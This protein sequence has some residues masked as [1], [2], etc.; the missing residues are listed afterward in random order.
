MSRERLV[1]V[2]AGQAGV[3]AALQAR[4]LGYEGEITLLGDEQHLPYQRPH[5]SKAF[6]ES[7]DPAARPLVPESAY[8]ENDLQLI[9]GRRGTAIDREAGA[10]ELDDGTRLPYDRLVL[11]TGSRNRPLP[12]G[13]PSQDS[14][15][16]GLRTLA[17]AH[18]LHGGLGPERRVVIIGGG[19]IGLE[20]A[21]AARKHGATVTVLEGLDRLM[22]RSLS[23]TTAGYLLDAHRR[24][25]VEVTLGARVAALEIEADEEGGTVELADGTRILA[26]TVLIGI[27]VLPNVELAEAAGLAVDDGIVVDETL[28]TSDPA[29][30]AIGDC[31]RHPCAVTGRS[32]R[33]ESIQNASGHADCVAAV[34]TGQ[35][36]AYAEVP[37]FWTNQYAHRVQIAG[38]A[39]PE[40]DEVLR[41]D[42]ESAG[43][44]ILRYRGERLTS[45]ES[46]DR[47][48]DHL[49]G[50]TLLAAR[51]SPTR[52]QSADTGVD[53]RALAKAAS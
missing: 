41:R 6:L 45:V 25:G 50:R 47:P 14:L 53:L 27:G 40:D 10:V 1:V 51:V 20:A 48:A 39:E 44:S 2:G 33:L 46:V 29:I 5:L 21:A 8:K 42:E 13:D 9:L 22:S 24:E 32:L 16:P 49:A 7:T 17:D 19:F 11:A 38:V 52:E 26:D 12:G 30:F 3:R 36:N 23:A 34:L 28:R 15:H 4:K 35:E 43:F 31:A 37:W 18:T